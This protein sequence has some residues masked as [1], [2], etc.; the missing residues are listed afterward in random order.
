VLNK[1]PQAPVSGQFA[2]NGF[3]PT[4]VVSYTLASSAPTTITA[5]SS[6]AWSSI[7]TFAPYTATLLVIT[8]TTAATPASAWD[9]NPDTTMVAAGGTVTLRPRI[10][11]GTAGV[12]L[13]NAQSDNGITV[14]VTQGNLTTSQNGALKVVAGSTPGFYHYSVQGTDSGATQTEGGWIVVGN[15]A[16]TISKT[17]DNQTGGTL[18]LTATLVPGSSGGTATGASILFTTNKGVL[19]QRIVTTDGSG[20][21]TV[22]LTLP[23]GSGTTTVTAEGPY[24]LGHPVVTFTEN[25]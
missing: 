16:A 19:S 25:N 15:S 17:G 8:G 2:F 13:T 18:T 14:T 22:T 10:T 11:N 12:S 9:L 7:Q 1:D 24:G 4:S 3:T 20:N 5:S 21:A 6:S 23:S